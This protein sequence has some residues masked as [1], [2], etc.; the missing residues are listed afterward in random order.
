MF[1]FFE[2]SA[3][4]SFDP[5]LFQMALGIVLIA[6]AS[7]LAFRCLRFCENLREQRPELFEP[8]PENVGYVLQPY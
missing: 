8:D 3:S 1:G 2:K 4:I 5:N 7:L 6:S